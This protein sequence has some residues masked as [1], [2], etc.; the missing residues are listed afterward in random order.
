[1]LKICCI[2]LLWQNNSHRITDSVF[3]EHPQEWGESPCQKLHPSR[4]MAL[5]AP[6]RGRNPFTDAE[7]QL[8]FPPSNQIKITFIWDLWRLSRLHTQ[9]AENSA[10]FK[11]ISLPCF[12]HTLKIPLKIWTNVWM[13]LIL[14]PHPFYALNEHSSWKNWMIEILFIHRTG[15]A[16]FW[17]CLPFN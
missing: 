3:L 7:P 10:A 16:V 13:R 8:P 15:M 14:P 6:D 4:E 17:V 11:P 2:S 12:P 1:M 5:H 9:I